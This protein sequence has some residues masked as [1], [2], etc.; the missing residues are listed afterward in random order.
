M[1]GLDVVMDPRGFA[2]V[3][4]A[5]ALTPEKALA[6]F[7]NL[8]GHD[9]HEPGMDVLYDLRE[10]DLSRLQADEMKVMFSRLGELPPADRAAIVVREDVDYGVMRMWF[11]FSSTN[12]GE[13][14]I[15]REVEAAERWLAGAG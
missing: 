14:K 10:A 12:A 4:A 2:R 8:Y 9:D 13:R 7:R 1:T 3:R 15:F 6:I 5:G 11:V